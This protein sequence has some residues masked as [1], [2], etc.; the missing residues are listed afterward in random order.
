M[1]ACMFAHLCAE[2]EKNSDSI[3]KI[4]MADQGTIKP[5]YHFH[6]RCHISCP[7]FLKIISNL[8]ID[9]Q[10]IAIVSQPIPE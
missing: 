7:I 10:N 1:H 3:L 9:T 8:M 2:S 6:G 5:I 4:V